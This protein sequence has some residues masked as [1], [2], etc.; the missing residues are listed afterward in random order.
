MK[1]DYLIKA[2]K[3]LL[4]ALEK[5]KVDGI[6]TDYEERN[7]LKLCKEAPE[8]INKT[9]KEHPDVMDPKEWC[10]VKIYGVKDFDKFIAI[11]N[12]LI[13]D[14]EVRFD[15]GG[16]T[17]YLYWELDWSFDTF[18]DSEAKHLYFKV[19]ESLDDE[20]EKMC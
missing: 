5:M 19:I 17:D 6:I 4:D 11:R 15:T 9:I 13:N 8:F 2:K 7:R 20:L 12:K 3:E 10:N 1:S 18:K 14:L 16:C